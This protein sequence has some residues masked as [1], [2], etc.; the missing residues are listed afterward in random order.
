MGTEHRSHPLG[1]QS[2]LHRSAHVRARNRPHLHEDVAVRRPRERSQGAGRLLHNDAARTAADPGARCRQRAA[3]VLQHVPSPRLAR[4]DGHLRSRRRDALPL[5]QLGLRPR[6]QADRHSRRGGVRRQRFRQGREP[7]RRGALRGRA[8]L[9]IRQLQRGRAGAARLSR[10]EDR[11]DALHAARQRPLRIGE[12]QR[13]RLAGELESLRRERARRLPRPVRAP[14]LSQGQPAGAVLPARQRTCRAE[15]RHGFEGHRA[16]A[17]GALA[18][19]YAA[20]RHDRR[21]LHR[22]ALPRRDD[23]AA[24]ERDLGRFDSARSGRKPCTWRAACLA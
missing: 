16:A 9:G 8:G 3:R 5:P 20:R 22:H 14:V 12:V 18:G 19:A 15:A 17:V 6:R 24:L 23:H 21:R 4:A 7:A 1:G 10:P 11:R 2:A 13:L